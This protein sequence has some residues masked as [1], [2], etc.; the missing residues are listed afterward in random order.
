MGHDAETLRTDE[1][2]PDCS[3]ACG[4]AAG[5]GGDE[6][7]AASSPPEEDV[8]TSPAALAEVEELKE[9]STWRR[10][11]FDL[12]SSTA[13]QSTEREEEVR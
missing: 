6:D 12:R 8:P 9:L 7:N 13:A 11:F 3:D 5:G 4:R 10:G 1:V 2:A